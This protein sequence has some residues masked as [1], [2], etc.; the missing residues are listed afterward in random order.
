MKEILRIENL[1]VKKNKN[2]QDILNNIFLA[3]NEAQIMGLIGQSGS[4]KT[5]CAKSILQLHSNTSTFKTT[6]RILW[7]GCNL[8]ELNEKQM[9][10]IRG[11]QIAYICQNPMNSFNPT[12]K[13]A[14]QMIEGFTIHQNISVKAA[15][16]KSI[17]LLDKVGFENPEK[18][19]DLYPH[20]FSGGMLQRVAI[21]IALINKPTLILADEITT[22]LDIC[23]ELQILD[24]LKRLK[25]EYNLSILF[26][27][28]D[29]ALAKYFCDT[30]SVMYQ[31]NIIETNETE[32]LFD[33]PVHNHTKELI[34][35]I[36]NFKSRC[37]S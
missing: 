1:N 7:R 33:A 35:S 19:I 24:L 31:K 5:M 13:I 27:T 17:E 23:V 6:G 26:I 10:K 30:I 34:D 9:C 18:Q 14:S 22:S 15:K 12:R 11:S 29:L 36:L 20:E 28:H 32:R 2:N 4:G 16:K 25:K 37:H 3:I 8:L 21:A